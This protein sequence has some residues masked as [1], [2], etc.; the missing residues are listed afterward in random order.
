MRKHPRAI[1]LVLA[2][3]LVLILALALLLTHSKSRSPAASAPSGRPGSEA[4]TSAGGGESASGFDGAALP[5]G[6]PAHDFTLTNALTG[7]PVSLSRDRG[8]VTVLAFPYSACGAACTLLA[9]QVRGALDELPRPVPVLFVSADPG[10]DSRTRVS[11]FLASVSLSGRV[12]YLTGSPAAL[13]A[14]WRAYGVVPA[15]AGATAYASHAEVFLLD[16]Q[17]G[18]RVIFGLEQLTPEGLAH[19]ICKLDGGCG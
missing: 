5:A 14:V 17:G 9:Q 10:A 16:A 11:R 7:Q 12:Q 18:E 15:S 2:S 4:G 3:A 13:G 19:D 8:Q 1:L 6:V